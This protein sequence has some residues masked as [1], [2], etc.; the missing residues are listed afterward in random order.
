[1]SGA[2]LAG[3]RQQGP[4]HVCP[5]RRHAA[6]RRSHATPLLLPP[7]AGWAYSESLVR[8]LDDYRRRFPWLWAAIEQDA[9][10][11]EAQAAPAGSGV[12][13]KRHKR[14]PPCPHAPPSL[15]YPAFTCPSRVQAG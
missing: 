13:G 10:P 9:S 15:A 7:P 14:P 4:V 11:G 12:A 2:W 8:V 3:A 1:M 5:S 6:V